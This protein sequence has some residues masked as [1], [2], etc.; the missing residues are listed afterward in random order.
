MCIPVFFN[1]S[2]LPLSVQIISLHPSSPDKASN[3]NASLRDFVFGGGGAMWREKIMMSK[4]DPRLL[5]DLCDI[6]TG[7]NSHTPSLPPSTP[8]ALPLSR[9]IAPQARRNAFQAREN[10][11]SRSSSSGPLR[12][13]DV[14]VAPKASLGMAKTSAM[15]RTK[16]RRMG[17]PTK[18][19]GTRVPERKCTRKVSPQKGGAE[20]GPAREFS[21]SKDQQN[22]VDLVAEGKSVFFTGESVFQSASEM[23]AWFGSGWW[24]RRGGELDQ[25]KQVV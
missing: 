14:N 1:E 2:L 9:S 4:A 3:K 23:E 5:E 6:L 20:A 19:T 21:L 16:E 12:P 13:R 15:V 17:T 18:G 8:S 11:P 22:V 25:V 7:Q 24:D 10:Q